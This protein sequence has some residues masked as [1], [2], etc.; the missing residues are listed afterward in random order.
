[1]KQIEI[2][3]CLKQQEQQHQQQQFLNKR[4]WFD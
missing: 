3:F 1:M 2:N 4:I